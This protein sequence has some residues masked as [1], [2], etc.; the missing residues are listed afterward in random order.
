MIN[1]SLALGLALA[2]ALLWVFFGW[3]IG[4][5]VQSHNEFALAGR[6]VGLAFA[7]AT[8]M[9]TWVTSNTTLVAPQLTYQFGIWGMIGYACAAFGLLLFAPLSQRI[10]TL[11]PHGYTSG[12]FMRLRFGRF[13]W[14]VFLLI[15]FVY[16]MSWLVSLGMAGGIL[17]HT[18]S[19]L[20]YH[21]GMSIILLMC[22]VYTLFGGLKAVIATDFLQAII[23]LAGVVGIA[24]VVAMNVGLEPI[25]QKLSS[26]HP[27]LLDLLFPAAVMFLFN[28]IFFGLG[29]I[30]HS[31]VWWSRAFAFKGGVGKKAYFIAGLL[32]LPIPIVTGFIALAA[33][34]LGLYP[35]S[36]D[37]VGPLVA[38]QVLGYTGSIIL[39]IVVFSALA[40]SLDSLLAAT[41]DL[42]NQDI[43]LQYIKP[44]ASDSERL[45]SA[46]WIIVILGVVTWLLCLPKIA[47]LGALLNFA[48]AFVAST[49]WPIVFGLYF[50]RMT[51][52]SAGWAML[53]GTL[54]GL[55]GYFYIGFYVAALVSCAVSLL[56]CVIAWR[57]SQQS[58]HWQALGTQSKVEDV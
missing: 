57:F 31:N 37:M 47:T 18:L 20:D 49:I 5:R 33:P 6:N 9:A 7:C 24:I 55:I 21:L 35:A 36:A 25:H 8:A 39:F 26:D 29:E 42:I 41:S 38:S 17:L 4:R 54:S 44:K 15:S 28:N 1:A 10:K 50:A 22:V 11:L 48:G 2:F 14:W 12:D 45:K 32:W 58:F 34:S 51:G 27:K 43:Y 46:K 40:S 53:L 23:I 56:V 30:F 19:G 13:S 52:N 3:W 16:A